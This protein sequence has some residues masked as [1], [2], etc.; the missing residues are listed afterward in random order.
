MDFS[1]ETL[2]VVIMIAEYDTV[3]VIR[4]YILVITPISQMHH[5][6]VGSITSCYRHER[7]VFQASHQCVTESVWCGGAQVG[8]SVPGRVKPIT[9]TIDICHFLA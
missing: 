5:M 9:Y 8:S 6:R 2:N 3:A 7:K 4:Q 1:I